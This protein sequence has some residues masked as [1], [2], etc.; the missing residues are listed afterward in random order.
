[1]QTFVMTVARKR[2]MRAVEAGL[3]KCRHTGNGNVIICR[4]SGANPRVL[5]GL[6]YGGLIERG[7]SRGNVASLVLTSAGKTVLEETSVPPLP[8]S[9]NVTSIKSG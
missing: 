3:V 4:T 9:Q 6:M 2:A 7:P 5:L 1:M 8:T